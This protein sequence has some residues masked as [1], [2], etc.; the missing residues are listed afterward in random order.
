MEDFTLYSFRD[1]RK[2]VVK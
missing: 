1:I 2:L